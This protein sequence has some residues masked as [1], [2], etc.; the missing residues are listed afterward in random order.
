M[1]MINNINKY[2]NNIA[3]I[4]ENDEI[5]R[6]KTLSNL[7]EKISTKIKT[8]CLVFLLCDNGVESIS[9]YL[10]FLQSDCVIMLLDNKISDFNLNKLVSIYK[11]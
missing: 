11:P 2:R 6:Y 1:Q 9:G 4:T 5:I 3:L 10:A 8:R 7:S